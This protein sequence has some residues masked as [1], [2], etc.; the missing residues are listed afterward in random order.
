MSIIVFVGWVSHSS[1]LLDR[2]LY[3]NILIRVD[4]TFW[5]VIKLSV[6]FWHIDWI[7]YHVSIYYWTKCHVLTYVCL[8]LDP[9]GG[10][11]LNLHWIDNLRLYMSMNYETLCYFSICM[12]YFVLIFCLYLAYWSS[13]MILPVHFIYVYWYYI[14]VT[15]DKITKILLDKWKLANTSFQTFLENPRTESQSTR[16]IMWKNILVE[17]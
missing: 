13:H 10:V 14:F 4:V 11:L 1:T 12:D 15:L 7:I 6:I 3:F 8:G 2:V 17:F 9:L 16:K 5:Y